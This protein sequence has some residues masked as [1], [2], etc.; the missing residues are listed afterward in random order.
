MGSFVKRCPRCDSNNTAW[1]YQRVGGFNGRSVFCKDC[2]LRLTHSS[3]DYLY[4]RWNHSKEDQA[5]YLIPLVSKAPDNLAYSHKVLVE[6]WGGEEALC[7]YLSKECGRKVICMPCM[8]NPEG[9]LF[10]GV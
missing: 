8:Y 9:V 5:A 3:A 6:I 2:G 7:S 10:K 4:W 1:K